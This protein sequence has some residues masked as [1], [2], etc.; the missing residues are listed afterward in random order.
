MKSLF[1]FG[2]IAAVSVSCFVL[3]ACSTTD[4]TGE[5]GERAKKDDNALTELSAGRDAR[6]HREFHQW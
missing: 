3:P 4:A 5:Q 6:V 2:Q 1:K